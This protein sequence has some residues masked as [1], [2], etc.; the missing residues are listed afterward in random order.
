M[1]LGSAILPIGFVF[2]PAC[3]SLN[4]GSIVCLL[5]QGITAEK[6]GLRL[7]DVLEF[8]LNFISSGSLKYLRLHARLRDNVHSEAG[9][10]SFSLTRHFLPREEPKF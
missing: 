7:L 4:V 2:M 1:D 9:Y 6:K 10:S 5:V 3:L 8:G